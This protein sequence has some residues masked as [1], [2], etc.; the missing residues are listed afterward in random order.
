VDGA[1]VCSGKV[2][3]IGWDIQSCGLLLFGKVLIVDA[4]LVQGQNGGGVVC[5]GWTDGHFCAFGV[6]RLGWIFQIAHRPRLPMIE[7]IYQSK[8]G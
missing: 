1:D 8:K 5:C 6:A 4:L 3:Q 2:L 7:R